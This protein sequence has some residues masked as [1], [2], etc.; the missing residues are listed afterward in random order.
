MQRQPYRRDD[1]WARD[2]RYLGTGNPGADRDGR[3]KWITFA[4]DVPPELADELLKA[5]RKNL[6]VNWTSGSKANL[7]RAAL[8][9]YLDT[10]DP[11]RPDPADGALV[12]EGEDVPIRPE[13][14]ACT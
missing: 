14:E 8:Q 1:A 5:Y 11:E 6:G 12:T 3:E 13:L 2:K 9:L 10:F 4:A 7:V